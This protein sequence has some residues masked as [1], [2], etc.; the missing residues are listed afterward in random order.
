[1]GAAVLIAGVLGGTSVSVQAE[2][3]D[4][5]A[6]KIGMTLADVVESFGQ[7]L[8]L[9]WVNFKGQAVLFLFYP[10][11]GLF[12]GLKQEDG[13]KSIPLGFVTEKLSGWGRKFYEQTKLPDS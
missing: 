7:P 8:R 11:D 6:L 10:Y 1:L 9:E 13:R 12:D 3:L 2:S 4:K 5:D